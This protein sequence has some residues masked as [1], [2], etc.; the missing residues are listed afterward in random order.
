MLDMSCLFFQSLVPMIHVLFARG[1]STFLTYEIQTLFSNALVS[2]KTSFF[3]DFKVVCIYISY[4]TYHLIKLWRTRDFSYFL[5]WS[6]MQSYELVHNDF[7][8]FNYTHFK[9]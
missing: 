9:L 1:K 2:I 7:D 6:P 5:F 4:V 8:L 3:I